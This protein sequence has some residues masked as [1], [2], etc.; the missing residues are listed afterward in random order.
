MNFVQIFIFLK[1]SFL[2]R[3]RTRSR[4][5]CYQSRLGKPRFRNDRD[6][7]SILFSTTY[8]DEISIFGLSK[9]QTF[10]IRCTLMNPEPIL[11]LVTHLVE[12]KISEF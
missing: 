9:D 7:E 11:I 3:S 10:K 6:P 12:F 2:S 5:G 1:I 8:F 4:L